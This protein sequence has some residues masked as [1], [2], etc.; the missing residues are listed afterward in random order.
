MAASQ[1]RQRIWEPGHV[2]ALAP[3]VAVSPWPLAGA[4]DVLAGSLLYEFTSGKAHALI[5]VRPVDRESGRR[6]DVVGLVSDGER[7]RSAEL[8]VALLSIAHELGCQVMAMCTKVPHVIKSCARRGWEIS[9]MVMVKEI[10]N[11]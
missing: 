3:S 2:T 1:V 7:L 10:G 6:L 9:G 4:L 11:V 5:A 8:D